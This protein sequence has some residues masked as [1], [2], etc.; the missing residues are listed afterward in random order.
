MVIL[1]PV[2]KLLGDRDE[3]SNGDIAD[4]LN[5]IEKMAYTVDAAVVLA[6]HF[7]KGDSTAKNAI[8]RLSGAGVWARDPDTLL[9]LTPHEEENCF[10]ASTIV[11]YFPRIPEFVVGWEFPL[12]K[13]MPDLNPDSLRRPQARNKNFTDKE[14][15]DQFI[16]EAPTSRAAIVQKVVEAGA[17]AST[18]DR[19]LRRLAEA[20]LISTSSGLY[21]RKE[22][23]NE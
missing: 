10:T 18:A 2:Y 20:G 7:A 17:S 11:R 23:T 22:A 5:E 9:V 13:L 4:L 19:Y 21:W 8:D 15:M 3:N 16:P 6:H 12:M 1:D 14:F